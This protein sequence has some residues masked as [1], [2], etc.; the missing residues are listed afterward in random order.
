VVFSTLRVVIV[1]Y[2]YGTRK[3]CA[4]LVSS[5]LPILKMCR[6]DRYILS[7]TMHIGSLLSPLTRIL[8]FGQVPSTTPTKDLRQMKKVRIDYFPATNTEEVFKFKHNS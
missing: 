8:S 2:G 1:P 4:F 7:K 6:A 5:S 3:R